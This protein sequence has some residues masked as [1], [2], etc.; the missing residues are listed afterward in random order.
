M[1]NC[2]TEI[3]PE[4]HP[5]KSTCWQVMKKLQ[6]QNSELLGMGILDR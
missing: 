6:S 3:T 4:I 2:F 5:Q 1:G